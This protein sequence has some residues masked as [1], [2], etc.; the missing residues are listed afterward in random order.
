M[1][2]F[3]K[4]GLRSLN[5]TLLTL[6]LFAAGNLKVAAQSILELSADDLE[7]LDILFEPV[8][9]LTAGDGFRVA[10]WVIN[11]P[12]SSF[13]I[14]TRFAGVVTQWHATGGSQVYADAAIVTL[15]S[16]DLMT[17]QQQWLAAQQNSSQLQAELSK[18]QQLFKEGIIPRL[19]L[20]QSERNYHQAQFD[21]RALQQQ[22]LLAGL[23]EQELTQ[24]A[25]GSLNPGEITLRAPQMGYLSRN[26]LHVGDAV[27]A[28]QALASVTNEADLWLR[29]DVNLSLAATLNNG[30][31]LQVEQG[32]YQATLV[33]KNR[34]LAENTQTVELLAKFERAPQLQPGQ[35]VTLLL[36]ADT[37]GWLIPAGAVTHSEQRTQIYV[38]QPQ[39]IAVRTLDLIPMGEG[40]LASSGLS[41]GEEIVTRG[42]A[43]LKGIEM[44]LGGS[45]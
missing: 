5:V 4:P 40:Y 26:Y 24:L 19:R 37:R 33:S 42:T 31:S 13:T 32:E 34:V 22:L 36:G 11:S 30:D 29:A 41:E 9:P 16:N 18:D 45:E 12:E 39:G 6:T 10:A 2:W 35:Q 25:A 7:R 3:R 17:A 20:Q 27:A 8:R 28:N 44:G 23:S 38:K 14:S 21:A 1:K 43:L 15:V